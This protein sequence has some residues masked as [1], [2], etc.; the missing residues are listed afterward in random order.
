[1]AVGGPEKWSGGGG[2]N[3]PGGPCGGPNPAGPAGPA[4]GA[5]DGASW[6]APCG[7]AGAPAYDGTGYWAVRESPVEA[8]ASRP[9]S[10]CS[11][12]MPPTMR[13]N[14]EGVLRTT[15]ESRRK[16]TIGAHPLTAPATSPS[17]SR[18]CAITKNTIT[19]IVISVDAA[20]TAP[21]SVACCPKNRRSPTATV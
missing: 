4:E 1:M 3:P 7:D 2:K 17:V 12:F 8:L 18:F 10:L 14:S 20:I 6:P 21:Q 9:C 19:G 5:A 11:S 13:P 15:W 16:R